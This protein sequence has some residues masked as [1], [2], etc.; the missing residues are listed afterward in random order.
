MLDL[1][2]TNKEFIE[3]ITE[4]IDTTHNYIENA[5]PLVK[6]LGDSF[7]HNPNKDSWDQ[8]IDLFDGISWII[9]TLSII[10]HTDNLDTIVNN[11]ET[12]NEYVQTVSKLKDIAGDMEPALESED[13][14]LVG[15]LLIYEIT[16]IFEEMLG[17]LAFL[18][19]EANQNAN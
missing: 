16:P 13:T 19:S 9:E 10:D 14:I 17:K 8:L 3:T 11:Y 12:W 7:Y 4:I 18:K 2:N 5:I 1:N 6:K 15:D